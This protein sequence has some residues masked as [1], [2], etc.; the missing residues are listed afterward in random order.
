MFLMNFNSFNIIR[1]LNCVLTQSVERRVT[2]LTNIMEA[3]QLS[4]E[5]LCFMDESL[6]NVD[7]RYKSYT[8]HK[9]YKLFFDIFT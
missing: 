3:Y 2:N 1:K 7:L 6:G 9:K 8:L 4:A 5:Q